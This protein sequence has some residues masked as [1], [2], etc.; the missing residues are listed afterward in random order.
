M[1][2]LKKKMQ[3]QYTFST[4]LYNKVQR[5]LFL[6]QESVSILCTNTSGGAG[7]TPFLNWGSMTNSIMLD[8]LATWSRAVTENR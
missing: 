7:E 5:F 8:Q 2:S 4:Q 6:V 3:L 1:L